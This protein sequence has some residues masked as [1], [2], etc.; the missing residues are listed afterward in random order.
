[1]DSKQI[2]KERKERAAELRD[3]KKIQSLEKKGRSTIETARN[4]KAQIREKGIVFE[5]KR[6]EEFLKMLDRQTFTEPS[7]KEV[8]PKAPEKAERIV[9]SKKRKRMKKALIYPLY[10]ILFL[11]ILVLFLW[12][13]REYQSRN[14]IR[15]LQ[16]E[17]HSG[18]SE[19]QP[20]PAK[21]PDQKEKPMPES[22]SSDAI[23]ANAGVEEE[24]EMLPEMAALW[25]KNR[26]LAGWLTIQD[27]KIDYPVMYRPDDNDYYLTHDFEGNEDS[28]GLLVL[29]KRCDPKSEGCSVLIHGHNMHSGSMFGT[30]RQYR[31][32]SFYREHP[33]IFYRTLYE[34]RAYEIIAVLVSSVYNENT[35]D[36]RFF[37]YIEI[38]D[39]EKFLEYV[40]GVKEKALYDTGVT[41]QWGD[42]LITLSTCEYSKEN[43][44]LLVV[45]REIK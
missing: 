18:V 21:A 29:D 2:V 19:H 36:F 23:P 41:A 32:E 34:E 12:L 31:K 4:Y 8:L 20:L 17:M 26:D 44:R 38:D 16:E 39:E 6:G 5:S 22:I 27:T 25:E 9:P 37:D 15:A 28:N 30:L 3:E 13:Y 1:M 35:S 42:R 40:S 7:G 43:G 33:F 14:K 45:G 11:L 10:M 24:R